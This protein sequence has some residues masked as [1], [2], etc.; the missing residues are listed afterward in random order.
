MKVTVG[1][2]LHYVLPRG[3]RAGE[4]R[5]GVVARIQDFANGIVR[6]FLIVDPWTDQPLH[7][8][9]GSLATVR[10]N[11]LGKPGS[12]HRRESCPFVPDE[13]KAG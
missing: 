11:A 5:A 1:D 10:H 6:V 7:Q 12:W 3:P 4:C 13:W 8:D 9:L 2:M